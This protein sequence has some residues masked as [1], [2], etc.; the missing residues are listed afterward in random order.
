MLEV[1]TVELRR[2]RGVL[3]EQSNVNMQL[4]LSYMRYEKKA[5]EISTCI[6]F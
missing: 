6:S 1:G 5:S 2:D 4:S 3:I